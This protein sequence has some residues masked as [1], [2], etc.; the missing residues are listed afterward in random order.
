MSLYDRIR[1]TAKLACAQFDHPKVYLT[2]DEA[3]RKVTDW[4]PEPF[5]EANFICDASGNLHTYSYG[6]GIGKLIQD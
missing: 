2:I 6:K 5:E 4:H 3:H 1:S